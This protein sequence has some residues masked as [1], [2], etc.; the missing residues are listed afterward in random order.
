MD[1]MTSL[2]R[3]MF[4][5]A[6]HMDSI[7]NAVQ[8]LLSHPHVRSMGDILSEF[9]DAEDVK[10]QIVDGLCQWFPE[11]NREALDRKVR[12]WLNGKTQSLAKED[13][14]VVSRIFSLSLERAN[15]FLKMAAGEGIHWRNPEDIVW[16]YSIVQ[17]LGPEESRSL[18][19][20]A[21]ALYEQPMAAAISAN[22]YTADVFE[23]LQ[24]V[25]YRSQEELLSFLEAQKDSLGA[26]HNTAY[27]LFFRFMDILSR[28]YEDGDVAA[29]FQEMT[30][31][32]KKRKEAEKADREATAR[33]ELEGWKS[34]QP[35][36]RTSEKEKRLQEMDG[37]TELYRPEAMSTS[38]I[39]ETYLYRS[40]VP[41]KERGKGSAEASFSAIQRSIRQ[42]WPDEATLSK[43]RSRK[44]DVSRKVLI[45]LFLATDGSGSDF[46]QDEDEEEPFTQEEQFLDL[47]ARMNFMLASCGF[48]K[49]DP[50][51]PFDWMILY[52]IST[53]DLWESDQRLPAMLRAAFPEG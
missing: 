3:E 22:A 39:L 40:L 51:N 42:N 24:P 14:F 13:A 46:T 4:E 5:Y 52:C 50:R 28:G 25:L 44:K 37:D 49:L 45:L 47:Y 9:S 31:K 38:E 12:N 32:E 16:A 21:N 17:N 18:L 41:V 34:A 23:K 10:K 20:R 33:M 43:M 15:E 48:Q 1:A 35:L 8:V 6:L 19:H 30:A 53:G 7:Q 36:N 2:S 26:L 29:L 11:N 27:Q